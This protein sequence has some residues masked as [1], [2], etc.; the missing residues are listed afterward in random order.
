MLRKYRRN[1]GSIEKM[2]EHRILS[3]QPIEWIIGERGTRINKQDQSA[4]WTGINTLCWPV[5]VSVSFVK[6]WNE[7]ITI[8]SQL[9]VVILRPGILIVRLP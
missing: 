4:E 5:E 9:P 7:R 3:G 6:V 2:H 1:V 8:N